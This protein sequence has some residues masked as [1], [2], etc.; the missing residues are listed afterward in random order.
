ME[1]RRGR[2]LVP[3]RPVNA[4]HPPRTQESISHGRCET[5]RPTIQPVMRF[6]VDDIASEKDPVLR[7]LLITQRYHEFAVQLRDAGI[8]E[9]ATWCA[10]AVW[11]SKT[12]GATIRGE[13]LPKNAEKA[14]LDNA[15]VQGF[16]QRFNHGITGWALTHLSHDH[17]AQA[18]K[19]ITEDVSASIA[20]GNVLVFAELAPLF[21]DLLAAHG[22]ADPPNPQV[23]TKAFAPTE[24]VLRAADDTAGVATAF[25][26]YRDALFAPPGR[27]TMVL[28]A[29]TLAVAHE[30][31]R[32]QPA[33]CK[34]LDAA[35]SDTLR[36]VVE[37][38]VVRF[39]PTSQARR[40]FDGLMDDLCRVLDQAWSEV[41]TESLMQ[42]VTASETFDLHRDVPKFRGHMFP[43]DLVDLSGTAAADAVATWDKTNGTGSPSGADN[44]TELPK[45][46]NFIVNLFRSRQRD[47]DLFK[48]P[49]KASQV[50]ALSRWEVPPGPL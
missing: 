41:L 43:V 38:D 28:Q 3:G 10:F 24:R 50:A 39:V 7:N 5:K 6:S 22:A 13:V 30:Q 4:A 14:I 18:V 27:A 12:A 21:T 31:Q 26:A 8:G 20:D 47:P 45:R 19:A 37:N 40:V 32:L 9:D 11:A 15:E 35:I 42:L 17:L 36:K 2:L 16:L 29:N 34:A 1:G 25:G 49:F 48:P 46:M 44:W 33:I 23:T